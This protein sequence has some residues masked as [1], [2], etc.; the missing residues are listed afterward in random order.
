MNVM[1]LE[2][3]DNTTLE[4]SKRPTTLQDQH[5]FHCGTVQRETDIGQFCL[6]WTEAAPVHDQRPRGFRFDER[7][8]EEKGATQSV[9]RQI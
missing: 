6:R 9:I 8:V 5:P 7:L 4:G 1:L 3:P 2:S